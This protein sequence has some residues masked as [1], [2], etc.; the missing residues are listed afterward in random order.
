VANASGPEKQ[1]GKLEVRAPGTTLP[2]DLYRVQIHKGESK[3]DQNTTTFKWA[4][5]N[6]S[7]AARVESI[8]SQRVTI[9]SNP[10]A[11]KF[12]VGNWIEITDEERVKGGLEGFFAKIN[13]IQGNDLIL[14]P[15]AG[16]VED[17]PE[18]GLDPQ[19]KITTVRIW[20]LK[21][22]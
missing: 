3:N 8:E 15:T 20:G 6:G 5:N 10:Q 18:A 9:I 7:V 19:S 14:D 13:N 4:R 17:I 22:A 16:D 12:E 21:Q 2:N 11:N 1:K